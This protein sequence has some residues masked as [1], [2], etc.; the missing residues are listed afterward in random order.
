VPAGLHAKK[1]QGPIDLA[2]L[3]PDSL[4]PKPTQL[5]VMVDNR[6]FWL[7]AAAPVQLHFERAWSYFLPRLGPGPISTRDSEII[8]DPN[9]HHVVA[10]T[11]ASPRQIVTMIVAGG[12]KFVLRATPRLTSESFKI[13]AVTLYLYRHKAGCILMADTPDKDHDSACSPR[14]RLRFEPRSA[15]FAPL[16]GRDFPGLLTL[17]KV[18]Y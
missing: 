17:A 5:A 8:T 18:S 11:L 16:A 6:D 12:R 9:T 10:R 3:Q 4:A 2:L 7:R 1:K 15:S 13:G 14:T